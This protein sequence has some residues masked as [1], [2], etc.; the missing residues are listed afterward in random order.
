MRPLKGVEL[1]R[2]LVQGE[3]KE[4]KMRWPRLALVG[5]DWLLAPSYF[6]CDCPV[7]SALTPLDDVWRDV[8]DIIG[9][10]LLPLS[11]AVSVVGG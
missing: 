5:G 10:T 4:T 7:Q 6:G 1:S 3:I 8:V 11:V 9:T 2:I